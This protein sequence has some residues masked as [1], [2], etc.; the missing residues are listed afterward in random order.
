MSRCLNLDKEAV[1]TGPFR[2][3]TWDPRGN[4]TLVKNESYWI[5]G[6]PYLDKVV[7]FYNFEASGAIAAFAAGK[8]DV[9]KV[10]D[11]AQFES[12]KAANPDAWG[13]PFAQNIS[14]HLI[15]KIDRPPFGDVRVRRALHLALDRQEMLNTLSFGEGT[16]NPPGMNGARKGWSITQEELAKL[17]GYRQPRD[18]DLA[19]AK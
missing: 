2:L 1:G 18:Q 9:V 19:E 15:M 12:V 5:S 17:P 10:T 16:M 13:E 3:T 7:L 14:D 4:A 8:N 11:K 6:R